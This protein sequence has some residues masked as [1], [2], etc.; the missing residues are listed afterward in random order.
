MAIAES[1]DVLAFSS[2][3]R[4]ISSSSDAPGLAPMFA[5]I[6]P[7]RAMTSPD[8]HSISLERVARSIQTESEG[9]KG[10]F[11]RRA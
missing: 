1:I 2:S 4:C 3:M 8:A 5:M 11:G 6:R 9:A 7:L 10:E